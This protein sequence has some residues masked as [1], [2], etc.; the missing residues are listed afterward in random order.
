[1]ILPCKWVIFRFHV[2]FPGCGIPVFSEKPKQEGA[3]RSTGI[4]EVPNRVTN[5]SCV[6]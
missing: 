4:P 2:T 3:F 1:M 6:A 5:P